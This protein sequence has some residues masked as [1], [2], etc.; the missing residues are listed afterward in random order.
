MKFLLAVV[1][2]VAAV[3]LNCNRKTSAIEI[4]TTTSVVNSGL[5]EAILPEFRE[6]AVRVHAA[7]SGRA[8]A[9]LAEQTVALVISH[10]PQ[11]EQQII[12]QH[13]SGTTASLLTTP[14][15]ASCAG[16]SMASSKYFPTIRPCSIPV[17]SFIAVMMWPRGNWR[18][19]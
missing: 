19:G 4:A 7:G 11:A 2:A 3:S 10:A 15:G 17:R 13:P 8:L 1:A 9:M 14:P 18:R 16:N 5:L 6:Y 12:E